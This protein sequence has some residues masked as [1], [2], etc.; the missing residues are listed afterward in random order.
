RT[1]RKLGHITLTS[2]SIDELN[3][4]IG[5]LKEYLP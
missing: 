1:G 2:N 5:S 3:K 4:T